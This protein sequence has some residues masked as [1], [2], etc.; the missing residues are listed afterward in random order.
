VLSTLLRAAIDHKCT[1]RYILGSASQYN[2]AELV[3][4]SNRE[5]VVVVIQYR[6]GLFG[7]HTF[8]ASKQKFTLNL[9]QGF[10]AGQQIKD[11]GALNAGLRM[12]IFFVSCQNFC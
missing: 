11:G 9:L 2:G 5:V 6:L 8:L 7:N 1:G 10:L 12:F 4:E 3:Q